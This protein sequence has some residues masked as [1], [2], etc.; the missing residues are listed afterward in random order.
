MKP[1][2]MIVR[3]LLPI[4]VLITTGAFADEC[5]PITDALAKVE[6]TPVRQISTYNLSGTWSAHELLYSDDAFY[7]KH[8]DVWDKKPHDGPQEA[9]SAVNDFQFKNPICTLR[10]SETIS[11]QMTEHYAAVEYLRGSDVAFD[12]FWI[13]PDTGLL[14]RW[15]SRFP[16]GEGTKNYDYVDIE[17][18]PGGVR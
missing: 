5:K 6:I 8:G 7:I 3:Y 12:D 14:A 11:G 1:S 10:G 18:P 13:S 9:A 15:H 16:G 17:P 2:A 4:L